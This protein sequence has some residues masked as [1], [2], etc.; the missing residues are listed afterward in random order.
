MWSYPC[1]HIMVAQGC[2]QA[3]L[4]YHTPSTTPILKQS[5]LC[6][7]S[8]LIKLNSLVILGC[9]IWGQD[10]EGGK[11]QEVFQCQRGHL[12]SE[13]SQAVQI[14]DGEACVLQEKSSSMA[15]LRVGHL[16]WPTPI[17]QFPWPYHGAFR[18]HTGLSQMAPALWEWQ[19][20]FS[21]SCP[22]TL[23]L[24][25]CSG[26]SPRVPLALLGSGCHLSWGSPIK[27]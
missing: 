27:N 8:W 25:C 12:P 22:I 6:H 21:A 20:C 2:C 24:Q 16:S 1:G 9:I 4:A 15:L 14:E 11:H 13:P 26:S 7:E 23:H 3:M 5:S 17:P 18:F 19:S 10:Q